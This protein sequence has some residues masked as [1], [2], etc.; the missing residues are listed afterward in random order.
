VIKKVPV[1]EGYCAPVSPVAQATDWRGHTRDVLLDGRRLRYLD[2]GE[3]TLGFVCVHG[4]GG[5]WQHWTPTLPMLSEHGRVLALDLPG[6]GAS[7][8][9]HQAITLELFADTAARLARLVG[10]KRVVF[11]GHSMGGPI[12]LRFATRHP[13]LA[14]KL[15]LV[16]GAVASF[17]A[18]LGLCDVGH[19]VRKQPIEALATYTEALT[20]PLPVPRSLR[21]AIAE[22]RRL[23]G[24]A[25]WP[26]VWSPKE[27]PP[28]TA[29][30]ILKGAGAKGAVRT[31]RAI[32]RSDP[33]EGL[34]KINCPILSVGGQHDRISPQADFHAF[35]RLAP[36][37]KSV[38][39]EG[40]GH[41]MMLER[42]N[43]FNEQIRR[44]L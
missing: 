14:H 42:P 26:Y 39:L 16:A 9:P 22:S 1:N 2:I 19:S 24:A 36:T 7:Q 17:S 11:I 21:R 23:R 33:Y 27:L 40:A 20:S 13:D 3:G 31:V 6:F 30:L 25:L 38:L 44:W 32:G 34:S 10:L 41:M 5:C 8:L 43:A 37:A 29:E 15:I 35:Q 12:A 28:A 4:L 18:L